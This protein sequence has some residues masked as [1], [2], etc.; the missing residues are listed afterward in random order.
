MAEMRK[1]ANFELLERIGQGGMGTV[2]KARQISMDR[3]VALKVLPP[4]MARQKKFI[5]RFVRE[6]RASARLNHPNIVNGI[7]VGHDNGLYYFAM[8]YVEGENLKDTIKKGCISEARV[9]DIG[10]AISRALAHA[11]ANGI[12]HRDIKPD[13]ILI[14]KHHT[15]KLCDLG[16][17]RLDNDTENE[18]QLT[19]Q[20]QAVGTPHY[21]SPEQARGEGNLD[22]KTDLYSL[23]ATMYHLVTGETPFDG[24]TSI[25][26]M[27]RHI[28]DKAPHPNERGVQL[29]K[30]MIAVLAKL[31]TKDR[32]DRYESAEQLADDLDRMANGK[33]PAHAELPAS[34][35]PFLTGAPS[36]AAAAKK[37]T[38]TSSIDKPRAARRDN[39]RTLAPQKSK[40]AAPLLLAGLAA[41]ALVIYFGR[42]KPQPLPSSTETADV[43]PDMRDT[44]KPVQPVQ[45]NKPPAVTRPVENKPPSLTRVAPTADAVGFRRP[46]NPTPRVAP[47]N[48]SVGFKPPVVA[49]SSSDSG[50]PPDKTETKKT[51]DPV[52]VATAEPK[53][54]TVPDIKAPPPE[55]IA[56]GAEVAALIAKAVTL[57][58]DCKYKEAAALFALPESKLKALDEFDR[59]EVKIHADA[60][61]GLLDMKAKVLEHL[62]NDPAKVDASKVTKKMMGAL[63]GGDDAKLLIK[64]PQFEIQ[65]DW[66]KLTLEELHTLC[67]LTLGGVIPDDIQLGLGVVSYDRGDDAAGRKF[68]S[69]VAHPSAKRLLE[70]ID[71]RDKV[72]IAR[73]VAEKNAQAE[74][75]Y[76]EVEAAM[77]EPNYQ[78]AVN[79]IAVL[80]SIYADTEK[81]KSVAA[82]L[83]STL[84]LAKLAV[85]SGAVVANGNVA[86]STNGATING[87]NNGANVIDGV[88]TGYT[89]S[90]GFGWLP[91]QSDFV[92]TFPKTYLMRE[93]RV[94]LWDADI[95][96]F[97]R[98]AV[99]VSADGKEFTSVADHTRGRW[100][101]WQTIKLAPRPVKAIK[102]H[103]VGNNANANGVHVVELEAY[104]KP[105]EQAAVPKGPSFPPGN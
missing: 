77:A 25:L 3:I 75:L 59:D 53:T 7:D 32:A 71:L 92:I 27:T 86:L 17:A 79:K 28:T 89:M 91:P 42:A 29:S 23:G 13:N 81:V 52:P 105:P 73:K 41:A 95:D 15:P 34:K 48:T 36:A 101:S 88:T 69:G 8:E 35:W 65:Y 94:L 6:A 67:T 50:S 97:Y 96:R 24:A 31:L 11:H 70:M 9:I 44:P 93:I 49:S 30:G 84:E 72:L 16:L 1:I 51:P 85:Q 54:V 66:H 58:N 5:E 12:L 60:F 102:F 19:Q 68:L 98:F 10:R 62:K 4:S 57:G 18:K 104:C 82:E 14:D 78:L 47:Q 61:A 99:E 39:T 26:V 45:L 100:R 22:A 43:Q 21:I 56:P 63:T 37:G 74:K 55:K 38:A 80:R 40:L 64:G 46:E 90:E 103:S 87:A 76:G 20:G 83:E 33:G 2:F